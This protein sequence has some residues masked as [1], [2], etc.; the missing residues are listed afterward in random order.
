MKNNQGIWPP[1]GGAVRGERG[2]MGEWVTKQPG[3]AGKANSRVAGPHTKIR[4]ARKKN[5]ERQNSLFPPPGDKPGG[6]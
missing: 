4:W 3:T 5:Q 1:G 6:W 2:G